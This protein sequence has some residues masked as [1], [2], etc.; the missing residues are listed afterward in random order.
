MYKTV[1]LHSVSNWCDTVTIRDE[2]G[3]RVLRE[4]REVIGRW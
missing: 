4:Q 2:H 3:L 1:I